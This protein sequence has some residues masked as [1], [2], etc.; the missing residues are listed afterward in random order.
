M[1]IVGASLGSAALRQPAIGGRPRCSRRVPHCSAHSLVAQKPRLEVIDGRI[2]S[3]DS[4]RPSR[5]EFRLPGRTR[6]NTEG[7]CKS[8]YQ[9][10][11]GGCALQVGFDS[12]PSIRQGIPTDRRRCPATAPRRAYGRRHTPPTGRGPVPPGSKAQSRSP[13]K[14]P[15]RRTL[16]PGGR[17]RVL[18]LSTLTARSTLSVHGVPVV[19]L[20]SGSQSSV[21]IASRRARDCAG[22]G[23]H[24]FGSRPSPQLSLD[25]EIE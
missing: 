9:L 11:A 7:Q 4:R 1:P 20:R 19:P 5:R 10:R 16:D 6:P 21:R 2:S 3:T 22:C 23:R 18:H 17:H 15:H 8:V 14:P 24:A 12:G 13:P 25:V